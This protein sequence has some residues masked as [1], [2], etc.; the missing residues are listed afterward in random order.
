MAAPSSPHGVRAP[1]PSAGGLSPEARV[2][3]I[4]QDMAQRREAQGRGVRL[5]WGLLHLS[6]AAIACLDLSSKMFAQYFGVNYFMVYYLESALAVLCSV[7]SLFNLWRYCRC[8]LPQ[9]PAANGTSPQRAALLSGVSPRRADATPVS[10]PP[11]PALQG[12]SVLSYSPG[13]AFTP[14]PRFSPASSLGGSGFPSSLASSSVSSA[15]SSSAASPVPP[16]SYSH[17]GYGQGSPGSPAR[18][19]GAT[20]PLESSLDSSGLR[21]RYRTSPAGPAAV[22]GPEELITDQ[23]TLHSFMQGEEELQRRRQL[24]MAE[25]SV[26]A[27]GAGAWAYSQSPAE[28]AQSLRKYAYQPACRSTQPS[29]HS[30]DEAD[31]GATTAADEVWAKVGTSR[32]QLENLDSWVASLRNWI[33]ETILVP[34]VKEVGI[35][36]R[37]LR[38]LGCPELQVGESSVPSLRQAVLLKAAAIPTLPRV[39]LYLDV[40][41]NQEYLWERI[42]DL[43][44][45]GC[46]S[47]FRW[48]GGGDYRGRKW[49]ADLPTDA[50]MVMHMLCTYLD[51]RLPPNPRYP[52]GKTFT[53]QH[54][55]RSPNKPDASSQ[56]QGLYI[57]QISTNPANYQLVYHGT[58]LELPKGRNNLFHTILMFLYIVKTKESGMLGRANLG[59]SGVNI[60]WIFGEQ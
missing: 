57:H 20:S 6:L 29:A 33:S 31:A 8:S 51:S 59:M 24:G 47:A 36:N 60:L 15:M 16:Y 43:A 19:M 1:P 54:F 41:A 22:L 37:H 5:A 49:D 55:Q 17:L 27:G 9:P 45:G 18:P 10:S 2:A 32:Q 25:W 58:A 4:A 39:L 11:P 44:D 46:M 28:C 7:S 38:R 21:L 42:K 34:L 50:V 52:D 35:V 23:K 48:N 53:S 12:Q 26:P 30:T 3:R 56:Q 14:S 13:R 40:T